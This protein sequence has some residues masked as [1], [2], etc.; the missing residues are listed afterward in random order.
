MINGK[1][2]EGKVAL[3]TGAGSGIG[4]A[5]AIGFAK[6]GATVIVT[7]ISSEGGKETVRMINEFNG[8]ALFY[9]SDITKS[10]AV[11]NLINT[12]VKTFGRLDYACN[13]AGI[14]GTPALTA[15]YPEE[16]WSRVIQVNLTG[17]WVCMKYEIEQMLTQGRGS[18]VNVSSILG[19]VSYA[20]ASAD[21]TSKHGLIGLTKTAAIEY[22]AH[23]I[24]V[25]AVCPGFALT[26]MLEREGVR[27]G[28]V[29]Y[30]VI[31][32]LQPLKRI[33]QPEEIAEAVIWLC[34][35]SSSF[36]TGHALVVDGGYISQ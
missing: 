28:S 5:C 4:R 6:E 26:P 17:T 2:A 22:A 24:R 20:N 33:A 21:V 7:D 16:I 25:N 18:I 31:A 30:D 9:K 10:T 35:D 29:Y 15:D 32:N 11:K 13:S 12:V 36:V 8:R 14:E 19:M 34:S 1:R 3:V 27:E 23:G